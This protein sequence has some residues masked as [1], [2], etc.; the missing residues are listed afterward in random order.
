[1][2]DNTADGVCFQTVGDLA[3]RTMTLTTGEGWR[4]LGSPVGDQTLNDLL[5]PLWTQG[6]SGADDTNGVPNVTFFNEPTDYVTP[7]DQSDASPRGVGLFAYIYADD[8]N[9]G[10]AEGFPKTVH[11]GG[12][13]VNGLGAPACG[14]APDPYNADFPYNLPVTFTD[15]ADPDTEDGWNLLANP[16]ADGMDWDAA[17]WTKT[18]MDASIYVWDPVTAQYLTWNGITGSLGDGEIGAFQGF[19]VK[20]NMATPV[21]QA[22]SAALISGGFFSGRTAAPLA[23]QTD[24]EAQERAARAVVLGFQVEAEAADVAS[25]Q[26]HVMFTREGARTH[27]PLDAYA[28]AS[29]APQHTRLYSLAP[30]TRGGEPSALSINALPQRA[31]QGERPQ[32]IPLV[33]EALTADG[34]AGSYTLSWPQLRNVPEGVTVLLTD[35]ETGTVLNLREETSYT[36]LYEAAAARSAAVAQVGAAT[37]QARRVQA[38]RRATAATLP[39]RVRASEAARFTLR[40]LPPGVTAEDDAATVGEAPATANS[41]VELPTEPALHTAYPNPFTARATLRY[42]VAEASP[43][44]VVVYDALGRVVARLVDAAVE[45]GRYT[46]TFEANGLASG[47]YIVRMTAGSFVQTQRLTLVR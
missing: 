6:F 36:F 26:T 35:T 14:G 31:L 47:L 16:F 28:L 5:S 18:N 34:G 29:L 43:V 9:D 45:P 33:F 8:N 11:V 3:T 17:G 13:P 42:D 24:P 27:D 25:A 7:S 2:E 37:E 38:G 41:V 46:T 40:L 23:E 39:A 12:D 20:A 44:R 22:P 4:M 10:S 30:E 21:L 32:Q 15:T 19:W 1:I